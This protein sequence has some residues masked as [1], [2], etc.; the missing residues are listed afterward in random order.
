MRP[1][2]SL[3]EFARFLFDRDGANEQ[4]ARRAQ[5]ELL[6]RYATVWANYEGIPSAQALRQANDLFDQLTMTADELQAEASR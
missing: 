1:L 6:R 3:E 5:S 4:E 2:P